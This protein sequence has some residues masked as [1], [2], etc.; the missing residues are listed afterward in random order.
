M[1]NSAGTVLSTLGTF[2]N[3][4]ATGGYAQHTFSLT[5]YIG[6]KITIKF[7]GRETL[8]GHTTNFFEDDNALHVS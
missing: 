7:T 2:S 3:L 1:L 5:R 8:A 6:Q 4:N